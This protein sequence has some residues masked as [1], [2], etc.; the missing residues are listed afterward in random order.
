MMFCK[1][2]LNNYDH[3]IRKPHQLSCPHTIC[4]E[5]IYKIKAI[6]NQCPTC[7]TPIREIHQ[8]IE[9]LEMIPESNYDKLKAETL[10]ILYKKESEI[11]EQLK[12]LNPIKDILNKHSNLFIDLINENKMESINEL[13]LIEKLFKVSLANAKSTIVSNRL[14]ENE[15]ED[16]NNK[17]NN[18]II[19]FQQ[20]SNNNFFSFEEI[21]IKNKVYYLF[22]DL[23][24]CY[25]KL[26]FI[27]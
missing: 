15:I 14:H 11:N 18:N 7:N 3:S 22:F 13:E 8:N 26:M 1:I 23:I 12:G 17:I 9:L 2:C 16:F 21:N 25:F 27:Y 24:G 4:I 5:C 10:K 20:N 6:S 19:D